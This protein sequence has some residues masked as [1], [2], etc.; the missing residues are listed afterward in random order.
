VW[1][2]GQSTGLDLG[3]GLKRLVSFNETDECIGGTALCDPWDACPPTLEITGTTCIRSRPTFQRW[4]RMWMNRDVC[5]GASV[6]VEVHV[7]RH[8]KHVLA[9]YDRRRVLTEQTTRLL[10]LVHR[11][12]T[13]AKKPVYDTHTHTHASTH[14]RTHAHAHA[15]TRLM[16]LFP[17]LPRSAGTR[18]AKPIWILV[19]QETV[20]GSGI[21]WAICKSATRSRQ[22]T[23]PAPHHSVFTGRM[24]FL[25]P[26]QQRQNTEVNV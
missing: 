15:H 17:G 21:S 23:T 8:G 4:L 2:P 26:N 13:C 25:P 14:A 24:P 19:K 6:L 18:K 10:E 5:R 3:T 11:D 12:K 9:R 20:S 22:T 7:S 16:A 1:S